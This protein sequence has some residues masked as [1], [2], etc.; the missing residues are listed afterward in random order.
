M[1][2]ILVSARISPIEHIAIIPMSTISVTLYLDS[3]VYL[4]VQI[5]PPNVINTTNII[6][7]SVGVI[8]LE[9]Q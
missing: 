3:V 5:N 8:I 7:K 6:T 4:K 2:I 1:V 9:Y